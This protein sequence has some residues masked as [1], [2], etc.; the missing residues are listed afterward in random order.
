V[1]RLASSTSQ[2]R[3]A[4]HGAEAVNHTSEPDDGSYKHR[5]LRIDPLLRPM[6]SDG[7]FGP[8]QELAARFNLRV[9]WHA[10]NDSSKHWSKRTIAGH[11]ATVQRN[12]GTPEHLLLLAAVNQ[13]S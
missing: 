10:L 2:R 1:S 13:S 6:C 3:R 12:E 7:S 4:A 9:D 8:P 11:V 5:F